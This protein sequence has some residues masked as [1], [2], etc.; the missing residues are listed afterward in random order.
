MEVPMQ[1]AFTQS[2]TGKLISF[3][4]QSSRDA[5]AEVQLK[6]S[7]MLRL[8][9]VTRLVTIRSTGGVLWV[10]Q[11][12]FPEDYVLRTGEKITLSKGGVIVIQALGWGRVQIMDA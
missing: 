7:S 8:E 5:L 3:T 11:Q 2:I 12:G 9:R 4:G 1:I 10:T 6:G